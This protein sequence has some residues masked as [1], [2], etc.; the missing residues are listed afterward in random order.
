MG[1]TSAPMSRADPTGRRVRSYCVPRS[2][3]T[4]S[5]QLC[6]DVGRGCRVSHWHAA[7]ETYAPHWESLWPTTV[8]IFLTQTARCHCVSTR[9]KAWCRAHALGSVTR[10]T[11]HGDCG[12]KGNVKSRLIGEARAH[13]LWAVAT[14]PEHSRG[15]L[16][17]AS[18]YILGLVSQ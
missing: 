1:S 16:E 13:Q 2:C 6:R 9:L 14:R 3:R 15:I 11:V 17:A 10:P 7:R 12:L 18:E 5:V 4:A 8:L